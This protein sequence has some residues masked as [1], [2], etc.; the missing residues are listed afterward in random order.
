MSAAVK[1]E[2]DRGGRREAPALSVPEIVRVIKMISA[3]EGTATQRAEAFAFAFPGVVERCP[4]LFQAACRGSVD[5]G[6][7]DF[8][9]AAAMRDDQEDAKEAVGLKLMTRFMR[10]QQ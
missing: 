9:A 4:A 5:P 2:M 3:Y 1:R 10:G 6:L 8:M 7:L